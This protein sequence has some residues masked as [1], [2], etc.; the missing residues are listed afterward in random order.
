MVR[1]ILHNLDNFCHVQYFPEIVINIKKSIDIQLEFIVRKP[2]MLVLM[3]GIPKT[4]AFVSC[5][6]VLE[7][8]KLTLIPQ[9]Y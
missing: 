7:E 5:Y 2:K 8:K 4:L 3:F 9:T 1:V 6:S